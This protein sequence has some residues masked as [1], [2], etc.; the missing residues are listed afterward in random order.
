MT[1]QNTITTLAI[2]LMLFTGRVVAQLWQY[3]APTDSLPPFSA[4]QSGLL[5]YPVLLASQIAI[6]AVVLWIILAIAGNRLGVYQ[7]TGAGLLAFG[8]LYF[9]FMAFR[10]V[11][12]LTFLKTSP[13]FGATLPAIF[14]LVL[15]TMVI[16]TAL[17]LRRKT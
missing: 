13:F 15:A 14:H 4:W 5:P 3:L 11:A 12:G 10:L 6:I 17:H 8:A 1:S 16:I 9:G 2:L 7:R